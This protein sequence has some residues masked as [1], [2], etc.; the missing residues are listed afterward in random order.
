MELKSK[1]LAQER[2]G[3][4]AATYATSRS[5]A[6]GGSLP[7]LVEL[8]APQPAWSALDIATGKRPAHDNRKREKRKFTMPLDAAARKEV[9]RLYHEENLD[10]NE[11]GR[12]CDVHRS[13]VERILNAWDV[14]RDE[15]REDGRKR[16]SRESRPKEGV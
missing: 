3:T 8:L 16:R 4:Y 13:T 9:I 6:K 1:S 5:H 2:F 12:R 7:R 10:F 14:E 11:V 15:K